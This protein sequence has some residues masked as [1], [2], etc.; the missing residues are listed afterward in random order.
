MLQH[1]ERYGV[2]VILNSEEVSCPVQAAA[3]RCSAGAQGCQ[4][5]QGSVYRVFTFIM[6]VQVFG[7]KSQEG[8]GRH[9]QTE[10]TSIEAG[11]QLGV[12]SH[13]G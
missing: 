2:L 9:A 11:V 8:F 6:I 5:R 13:V 10:M 3:N 1:E 12:I 4:R 7:C